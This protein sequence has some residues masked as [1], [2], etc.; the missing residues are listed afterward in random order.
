MSSILVRY[1]GTVRVLQEAGAA[2]HRFMKT[3]L[4]N[5]LTLCVWCGRSRLPQGTLEAC[6]RSVYHC[7]LRTGGESGPAKVLLGVLQTCSLIA[8][9]SLMVARVSNGAQY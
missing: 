3:S 6:R 7:R 4:P 9:V 8:S 5:P 2:A 1:S